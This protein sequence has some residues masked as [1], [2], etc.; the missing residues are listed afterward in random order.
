[1]VVVVSVTSV[2]VTSPIPVTGPPEST[3]QAHREKCQY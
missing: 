1:V 3:S 2:V